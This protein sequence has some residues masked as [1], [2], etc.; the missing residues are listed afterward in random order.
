MKPLYLLYGI[1]L[2]LMPLLLGLV[3]EPVDPHG[4]PSVLPWF[5]FYTLP[6]GVVGGLLLMIFG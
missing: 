1:V 3:A 4:W 5:V 2:G 6:V